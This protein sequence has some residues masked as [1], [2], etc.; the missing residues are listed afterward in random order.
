MSIKQENDRGTSHHKFHQVLS[1]YFVSP[2]SERAFKLVINSFMHCHKY[3]S[4]HNLT[5]NLQS[6]L[7]L[8]GVQYSF[9]FISLDI[10]FTVLQQMDNLWR[11]SILLVIILVW[12]ALKHWRERTSMSLEQSIIFQIYEQFYFCKSENSKLNILNTNSMENMAWV[13]KHSWYIFFI[14]N[15]I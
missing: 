3:L 4:E 14:N 6:T 8:C 7:W 10:S 12:K 13:I 2:C 1:K 5:K 9:L 15:W 11:W